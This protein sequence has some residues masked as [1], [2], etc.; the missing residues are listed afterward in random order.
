MADEGVEPAVAAKA[1]TD[2]CSL[3]TKQPVPP[4][5]RITCT[6]THIHRHARRSRQ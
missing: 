1:V 4:Q 3:D 6:G 2:F 5:I